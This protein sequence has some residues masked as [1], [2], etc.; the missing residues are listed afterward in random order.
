MSTMTKSEMAK[1]LAE[2]EAKL[3]NKGGDEPEYDNT[4]RGAV[5]Y[6]TTKKNQKKM[7]FAKIDIDGSA[8][9]FDGWI[10]K[11]GLDTK[12]PVMSLKRITEDEY[13]DRK[14]TADPSNP[15][16]Q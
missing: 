14:I 2:L 12:A 7:Y 9:Y 5:W 1:K 6:K 11:G 16:A 3:A 4:N 8:Y 10:A 15:L 13:V